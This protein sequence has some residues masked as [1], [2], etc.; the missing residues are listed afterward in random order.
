M[1]PDATNYNPD[2][3]YIADL[4]ESTGLTQEALGTL[5]GVTARTI[6]YWISGEREYPYIA[7]FALECLVLQV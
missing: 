5:L 4:I 6:R 1:T 7:Q 2:R 3:Q